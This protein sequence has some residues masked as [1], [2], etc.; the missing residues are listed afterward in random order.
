MHT[1]RMGLGLVLITTQ[2]VLACATVGSAGSGDALT[3]T[4]WKLSALPGQT[5]LTGRPA[6]LH[7]SEGRVH[8]SDGCNR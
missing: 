4:G 6:T 3:D 7:F 8:G 1:H 2:M 5:S